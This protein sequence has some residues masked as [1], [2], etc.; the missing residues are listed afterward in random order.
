MTEGGANV[1][2][3]CVMYAHARVQGGHIH[4]PFQIDESSLRGNSDFLMSKVPSTFLIKD[5]LFFHGV[6]IYLR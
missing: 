5:T 1:R 4:L 2:A 6:N 3:P